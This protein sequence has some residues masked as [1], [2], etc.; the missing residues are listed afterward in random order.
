V[1]ATSKAIGMGG[2]VL[3][4]LVTIPYVP[5]ARHEAIDF[6]V[7]FAGFQSLVPSFLC[8]HFF[9]LEWECFLCVIVS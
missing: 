9:L 7:F 8:C 3:L 2:P 6:N 5:S 4:E 1:A